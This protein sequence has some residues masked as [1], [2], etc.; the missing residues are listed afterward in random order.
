MRNISITLV[1]LICFL[2]QY[3]YAVDFDCNLVQDGGT[4]LKK[5]IISGDYGVFTLQDIHLAIDHL[6]NACCRG[7]G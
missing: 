6:F 5:Q 3:V 4:I 2:I 7:D 1:T